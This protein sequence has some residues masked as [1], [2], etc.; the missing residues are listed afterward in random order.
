MRFSL[1]CRALR[2]KARNEGSPSADKDFVHLDGRLPHRHGNHPGGSSAHARGM[3]QI[4][5]HHRNAADD[6]M[7]FADERRP[8]HRLP[9]LAAD[10]FVAFLDREIEFS[11]RRVHGTASHLSG[12]KSVRNARYHRIEAV[13]SG[14][15]VSVA[16]TAHGRKFVRLATRASRAADAYFGR[17]SAVA[18]IVSED[19]VFDEHGALRRHALVIHGDASPHTGESAVVYGGETGLCDSLP[20][21]A[22]EGTRVV[23]DG[24]R[25]ERMSDGLVKNH[26]AESV[27]HDNRHL[28]SGEVTRVEHPEG[29]FRGGSGEHRRIVSV[30][31]FITAEGARSFARDD[32]FRAVGR[33]DV[34]PSARVAMRMRVGKGFAVV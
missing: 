20:E 34:G 26:A 22:A 25:F 23:T 21:L 30:N 33:G 18:H 19:S 1:D 12:I 3:F 31:D 5:P 6:L 14:S 17:A 11:R 29:A 9:E 15:D 24:F 16:H 10:N 7:S 32:A 28:A 27:P 13:L 2:G 8:A 4:A